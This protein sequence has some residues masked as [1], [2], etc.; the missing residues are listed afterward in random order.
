MSADDIN[1]EA[2]P[3]PRDPHAPTDAELADLPDE[4]SPQPQ[5]QPEPAQSSQPEPQPEPQ[6]LAVPQPMLDPRPQTRESQVSDPPISQTGSSTTTFAIPVE[7]P[8]QTQLKRRSEAEGLTNA[9]RRRLRDEEDQEERLRA[10]DDAG[11]STAIEALDSLKHAFDAKPVKAVTDMVTGV[12]GGAYHMA[13]RTLNIVVDNIPKPLTDVANFAGDKLKDVGNFAGDNV[14]LLASTTGKL[15][16]S[17]P[18]VMINAIPDKLMSKETKQV[19]FV[20]FSNTIRSFFHTNILTIPYVFAQTGIATGMV[21][22]GIVAIFSL[23]ATETFFQA[24]Y[25]LTESNRVV[26]YGDVPRM[27]FGDWYPMLNIFYGV[28]HL[29][30]FQAFAARN[31]QVFL[32]QIGFTGDT[33]LLG[34]IVPGLL[35]TPLILM[36]QAAQQRPLSIVSNTLVFISCVTL[37]SVFPYAA[38]PAVVASTSA[39]QLSTAIGVVVYAFTGIGSAVPV[40]RTMEPLLYIKLLRISVAVSFVLLI[41][42]GLAGYMSFGANTCAV[43]TSSL[44]NGPAKTF[45]SVMLFIASIAI[46]PQQ[47]FPFAEVMDRRLLGLKK[48][49]EYWDR[50]ANMARLTALVGCASVAYLIPFYGLILSIG[51]ALGCGLLGLIIPAG[52]DYAR[53]KRMAFKNRRTLRWWEYGIVIS[54]GG[55]GIVA[56]IVG[57]FFSLF[58]MWQKIQAAGDSAARTSSCS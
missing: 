54:M 14:K 31:M 18:D 55:F 23:Y 13:D 35:A 22:N 5:P 21:L 41:G 34:L 16:E 38:K 49:P 29:I 52:L 10:Y 47:V 48:I 20:D 45:T 40:E 43:I 25:Q 36:K 51:G 7:A 56:L 26:V 19:V 8:P 15:I 50:R 11:D 3:V 6:P 53:R 12:V 28:I 17:A 46:I 39:S 1:K 9:E 42:F 44:P 4:T 58:A 24:K 30:S 2:S 33:Y 27:A 37:V 32:R 57:V